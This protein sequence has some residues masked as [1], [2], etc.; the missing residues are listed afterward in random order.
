[1]PGRRRQR[2]A[3][4]TA[5]AA[6]TSGDQEPAPAGF[7]VVGIG[8]SAG[9][10]DA[11][12]R[13]LDATPP[14]SGAAFILVQHLDPTHESLLVGLLADHTA[15]TVTEA[16][17]GQVI[18]PNHVYVIPPGAYL[19]VAG[20][21]LRLSQPRARHGA[22][23]P[24]DFLLK[25]LADAYGAHAVCV[26]LS[27][28]GADG[29]LGLAAIRESGGLTI[30]QDPGEAAHAG[31]PRSAIATGAV[32]LVL[33]LAQIPAAIAQF[34]RHLAPR[35]ASAP[36][37]GA[38]DETP[39]IIDLLR[40][41]TGHDFRLYKGGTVQRRIERRMA[42]AAIDPGDTR[43]YLARLEGSQ[44]ELDLL[45][46][47]LLIHVTSFFRDPKVFAQLAETTIPALIRDHSADQSLRVW[48]VGCST[49]E[50]A[51]SIAILMREAI[52]EAKVNLKLQIFASDVDADAVAVAR[53]GLYPESI[54]ADVSAE[55]LERFFSREERGWRVLP[56]LRAAV[57]FTVQDVL[58]D[59]PFSRI[60][61][62][63]CRNLMIYLTAE[64]QAKLIALFHFSL[65][66][67]GVLVLGSAETIGDA[68]D[69]FAAIAKPE[70][71]YRH[72]A[73]SRP[74]DLDMSI[75]APEGVRVPARPGQA[76]PPSRQS[77]LGELCRRLVLETYAPAAA[78]INAKGECV[79]LLGATD[80][81]LRV[82]AGPPTHD[83]IAMTPQS[84]RSK[85]R[86][87]VQQCRREATR[88]SVGGCSVEG[89][90]GPIHF[91][92]DVQ[93]VS[94]EGEAL[95]LIGF[96][97]QPA[98]DP[99]RG[100]GLAGADASRV[101]ELEAELEAS[102]TELQTAIHNLELSSE[103]QKAINEEALSVA[104][105]FQ[106][107]N[108]ELLTSKEELQSLNEEL[109][110][111]NGQLHESL[112]RQKTSANDLQ[113]ILYSTDL[114]MLFLD[115]QLNIRFF[116]PATRSLFNLI[117]T[118][119]GRPL[120]DLAS[121]APDLDLTP[122]ALGVLDSRTPIEREIETAAGLFF[123]RRILP[124]RTADNGV[125]GVV[126]TFTDITERKHAAQAL[127]AAR[128]KAEQADA[129]KSR[130]LAVASHDLRQP[131]QTLALIEGL[132]LSRTDLD[133]RAA[134]L[135]TRLGQTVGAM[136]GMFNTLLDINQ[137]E[138]GVIHPEPVS[139]P[140]QEMLG[141]LRD[142]CALQART[143]KLDLRLVDCRLWIHSD[144]RLL[145]QMIRNLISNALKYTT[146]GKVLIGCRRRGKALAIEVWDT[147]IGIA[148]GQLGAIFE[149]YHQIDNAARERARGLGLG[150]SI[151]DRLARLLDLGLSV[152]SSPA[153]GSVFTIEIPMVHAGPAPP[154]GRPP[155]GSAPEEAAGASSAGSILLVED[156]PDV[157]ELLAMV[158][159]GEG[160]HVARALDGAT[161]ARLVSQG[162]IRPDLII[163]DYNL[164]GDM[165]GIETVVAVR[166][167]L[168][169]PVP[170]L[171]I[172]G[173]ISTAALRK[174]ADHDCL[175]LS[176]PVTPS[177]LLPI[178]RSLLP[179]AGSADAPPAQPDARTVQ[180]ATVFVVDDDPAV[181]G[182]LREVLEEEGRTVRDF[183]SCEAFLDAYAA[184]P[185]T[186]LILDAY[187][188]GMNGLD[189]L[190]TLKAAGDRIPAIVI[191]G[192]SDTPIVVE[193][194]KSGAWDFIEK[195]IGREELMAAVG[196]A[197]EQARDSLGASVWRTAA[198]KTLAGLTERQRQIM[199]LVL[200]GHPSKNI[201]ADLRISQRTVENH[202]AA[203]MHR[204]GVKSLPALARMALI[205]AED[206]ATA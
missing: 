146:R 90:G 185:E 32:D 190:K 24:F 80:R 158:L 141:R 152:R 52:S 9:G 69:R 19:S 46:K 188:P 113:N 126:V 41:R 65:R 1:M 45:A 97:D 179:A 154:V 147:G 197:L 74:G 28:S 128:I 47:D 2:T 103:E 75:I 122:A 7:P 159:K 68:E 48:V 173:D 169:R 96:V 27:G 121:M 139:F 114:A 95:L 36:A 51:Y 183:G 176:K 111:L 202:R 13:L 119:V 82:P 21:A 30:A 123:A 149:A 104:E 203:I 34:G 194:M 83:L 60:D 43:S 5:A 193:A 25:S 63:S 171:V 161:A 38:E 53:D 135:V 125:E 191:T 109:T 153:K 40:R 89:P 70:R 100:E 168:R 39:R 118:D 120:A 102:R 112:E 22:R 178:I 29:S 54:A 200:E 87:A 182:A 93:Q 88:Q 77:V 184:A 85:M 170:V 177:D 58:I 124:Y 187:L 140:V 37:P 148:P 101:A 16:T 189:L 99:K 157:G 42:I 175:Q 142:E 6:L 18:A 144:P 186:C 61:L 57:V 17:E 133:E 62:I 201:A 196:R 12:S 130:F 8:A 134:G 64:A 14:D 129:A 137:I 33:A 164:P 72:I 174:I 86:S 78:L 66:Q 59:P 166:G 156:D 26:V 94:S 160:H 11:V 98:P 67:G 165:D 117:A 198:A 107:T 143:Q 181:R 49:G 151:V 172:T 23:L 180:E 132:L 116:T 91:R 105:E 92:L 20:G 131:L 162:K 110:A 15:M 3:S 76:P 84:L 115:A 167:A 127:E 199:D 56:D 71:L 192:N 35:P 10:L 136:T 155:P 55:R 79:H 163:A 31:M 50:E 106:S 138:A 44:I 145:E 73:R 4:D 204:L 150:L 108:E 206:A 205:A 81:Y 195:P